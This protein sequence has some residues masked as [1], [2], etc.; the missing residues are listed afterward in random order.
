MKY[1]TAVRLTLKVLGVFLIASATPTLIH[2]GIWFLAAFWGAGVTVV[3][4]FL[5]SCIGSGVQILIG[6]YL[7][8]GGRWIVD[9]AIPSNRPYCHECAYELTGLPPEGI[10]P[11]CGTPYQYAG[12]D[13]TRNRA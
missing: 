1:K 4:P 5:S 12:T 8:F 7:F 13:D 6:L 2:M 3:D 10:C 11:E 9:L